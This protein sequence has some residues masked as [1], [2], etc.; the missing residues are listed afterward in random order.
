MATGGGGARTAGP[1]P[2]DVPSQVGQHWSDLTT[3]WGQLGTG[4]DMSRHI[5]RPAWQ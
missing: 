5:S 2:E 4:Q 1:S 3:G